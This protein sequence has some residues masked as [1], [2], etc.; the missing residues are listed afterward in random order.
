MS[1]KEESIR[2]ILGSKTSDQSVHDQ[3]IQEALKTAADKNKKGLQLA[4]LGSIYDTFIGWVRLI[5]DIPSIS[6][7]QVREYGKRFQ[8]EIINNPDRMTVML[9]SQ[10]TEDPDIKGKVLELLKSIHPAWVQIIS[11]IFDPKKFDSDIDMEMVAWLM[12]GWI[13]NLFLLNHLG[14][15]DEMPEKQI[16]QFSKSPDQLLRIIVDKDK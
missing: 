12:T 5:D 16:D 7:S 1:A 15:P 3:A 9:K 4:V 2:S 10:C 6:F 11:K 13:S 8:H 14:R